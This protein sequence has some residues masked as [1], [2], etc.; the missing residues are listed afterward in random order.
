MNIVLKKYIIIFSLNLLKLSLVAIFLISVFFYSKKIGMFND[1]EILIQGNKFV[2]K[3]EIKDNISNHLLN[4]YFSIDLYEIKNNINEINFI[5]F[6]NVSR[7][8][9]NKLIINVIERK[10]LALI[11]LYND[12]YFIFNDTSILSAKESS[13]NYFPV[14]IVNINE[15]EEY[16]EKLNGKIV[17]VFQLL[18]SDYPLFYKQLS[19]VII[20]KNKWTFFSD[21]KTKIFT[22][23]SEVSNQI[24][25]LKAFESTVFPI[26]KLSDYSYIDLRISKQIIVKEK[27]TKG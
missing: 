1:Y 19:E 15:T 5:E 2:S 22:S 18:L 26:R 13:I 17:N 6:S 20:D 14:P 10:P 12:N 24:Y 16:D 23:A 9:P 21:S 27:N 25:I 7:V 3:N 4:N 11:T 8:F